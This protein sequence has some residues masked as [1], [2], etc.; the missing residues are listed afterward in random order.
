VL[1][2]G[3]GQATVTVSRSAPSAGLFTLDAAAL[4]ASVTAAFAPAALAASPTTSTLTFTVAAGAT[5]GQFPVTVR[6]T[7]ATATAGNA[8]IPLTVLPPATL[9]LAA[10][11]PTAAIAGLA[12]VA[13]TSSVVTITRSTGCSAPVDLTVL[14]APAGW[15]IAVAPT[16]VVITQAVN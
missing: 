9:G 5:A 11:V 10:T 7:S 4:L 3:T 14:N 13:G 8:T 12:T 2:G 1:P 15:T 6:V 16:T